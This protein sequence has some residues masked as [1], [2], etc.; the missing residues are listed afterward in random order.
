MV[1]PYKIIYRDI[2]TFYIT[3]S[4]LSIFTTVFLINTQWDLIFHSFHSLLRLNI[5]QHTFLVVQHNFVII[6][7][8]RH[9]IPKILSFATPT[10]IEGAV[11]KSSYSVFVSKTL[12]SCFGLIINTY[13]VFCI[14]FSCIVKSGNG[15]EMLFK[16]FS[17]CQ[18]R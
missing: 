18:F 6:R 7:Q 4:L 15:V 12:S 13:L 8:Q 11:V 1:F 16:R 9:V 17:F 14:L 10:S 2:C 5:F 3:T